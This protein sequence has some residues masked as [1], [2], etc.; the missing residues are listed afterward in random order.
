MDEN[1]KIDADAEAGLQEPAVG[2]TAN[3]SQVEELMVSR[4]Q[5]AIEYLQAALEIKDPLLANVAVMNA[6]LMFY[7]HQI[8][9]I[10]EPA[11][12]MAP[13]DLGE[14]TNLLPAMDSAL[15]VHRQSE[16]FSMFIAKLKRQQ[17]EVA[18]AISTAGKEPEPGPAEEGQPKA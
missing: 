1:T 3:S 7:S 8:R 16:R 5:K 11:F 17:D 6:D 9:R 2:H 18:K 15:R 12:K 4:E 13:A 14:L 10:V